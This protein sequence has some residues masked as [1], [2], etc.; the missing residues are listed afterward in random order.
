MVPAFRL[1][2]VAEIESA[3]ENDRV[4]QGIEDTRQRQE[5]PRVENMREDPAQYRLIETRR[6]NQPAGRKNSE[7]QAR[8]LC[9]QQPKPDRNEQHQHHVKDQNAEIERLL[10]EGENLKALHEQRCFEVWYILGIQPHR[11]G[12][13]KQVQHRECDDDLIEIDPA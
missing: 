6:S 3:I 4:G 7:E 12:R 1:V 9:L 8:P 10:G 2:P 5:R 11:P 13:H